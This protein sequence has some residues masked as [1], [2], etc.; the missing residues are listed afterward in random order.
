MRETVRTIAAE[1]GLGQRIRLRNCPDPGTI[2]D[3]RCHGGRIE[4]QADWDRA[5]ADQR[6][7]AEGEIEL[8]DE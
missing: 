8:L 6:W 5:P 3:V 7:Y 1:Y 2:T 4:Y